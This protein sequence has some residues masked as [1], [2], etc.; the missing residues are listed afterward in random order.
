MAKTRFAAST[1][2]V[3]QRLRMIARHERAVGEIISIGKNF[4]HDRQLVRFRRAR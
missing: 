1:W 3:Q 2:I 4:A